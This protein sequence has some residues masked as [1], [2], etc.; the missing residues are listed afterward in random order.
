MKTLDSLKKEN[1][2]ENKVKD[3]IINWSIFI[4]LSLVWG[5][6]FKLMKI[7]MNEF[8][9]YQ[10]ASLRIFSAGLFLL[11]LALKN[12]KGIEKKELLLIILSGMFGN[13]IPAYLFCIAE[14]KIDSSLAGIINSLMPIFVIV[15]GRLFFNLNIT[16]QKLI[17]VLI[18]FS[19][20]SALLAS[21]GFSHESNLFHI[22]LAI[23][24]TLLYGLNSNLIGSKLKNV[25]SIK[26]ISLSSSILSI[27]CL[28][29]LI[30]TGFFSN[31]S[32]E[33]EFLVSL[34]ASCILGIFGTALASGLFYILIKRAGS[35]FASLVT[36]TMPIVAV[37][38]GW[39]SGESVSLLEVIC[40]FIILNGVYYTNANFNKRL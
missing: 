36:N 34:T 15:I 32:L 28:F 21:K 24:A 20:L 12:I 13:Y 19:G 3:N 11:P 16:K 4:F 40:L 14:T 18:A 27:P 8:S 1:I 31:F 33:K 9:S 23:M 35:I 39:T 38:W 26:I 6:S 29:T 25:S 2:N 22:V 30:Y 10:V 17:G 37:F 7:G 5:S